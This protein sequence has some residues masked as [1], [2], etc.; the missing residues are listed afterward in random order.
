MEKIE[1]II[2]KKDENKQNFQNLTLKLKENLND[3][4][5]PD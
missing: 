5:L 4:D 2:P 3:C 1:E